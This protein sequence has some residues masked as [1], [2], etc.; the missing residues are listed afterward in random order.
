MF[1]YLVWQRKSSKSRQA[2]LVL[3]ASNCVQRER[4]N[5]ILKKWNLTINVVKRRSAFLTVIKRTFGTDM[6]RWLCC[7]MR[8]LT[9]SSSVSAWRKL[10]LLPYE[11]T[12]WSKEFRLM[13]LCSIP[14]LTDGTSCRVGFCTLDACR[15]SAIRPRHVRTDISRRT[16]TIHFPWI[17][18]KSRICS[19]VCW[20]WS[21]KVVPES[22]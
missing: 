14:N 20:T 19:V 21:H 18:D 2:L 7:F 10:H 1:A 16:C 3:T 12:P 13:T 22:T 15:H 17:V 9:S 11:Q 8:C 5:G 4:G 6:R